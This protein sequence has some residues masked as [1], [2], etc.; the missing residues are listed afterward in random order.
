V[1]G[2]LGGLPRPEVPPGPQRDLVDALHALHHEAGWPSLRVLAREAGCSHTTV[3]AV[4][5]S[6]RLPTWGVLELVVEAMR[7]NVAEFHRLWLAASSAPVGGPPPAPRIAGRRAELAVVR[8]HLEDGAGLLLVTGEAGIGKTRLVDTAADSVPGTFVARGACLPLSAQVPLMPISEVLRAVHDVDQGQWL[9]EALAECAPYVVASLRRLLP[10]L[11]QA[12]D[13]PAVPDDDWWRQR[14]LAAVAAVLFALADL[15]PLAVVVED[16]HWADSATLDVLEYL[17]A[18]TTRVPLVATFRSEDPSVPDDRA[19]WLARAQR[20]RTVSTLE[21]SVLTREESAELVDLLGSSLA[22]DHLDRIHRRS[23]GLPLFT[24]QLASHPTGEEGLPRALADVLDRRLADI[25]ADE[26]WTVVRAL[27]VADRPLADTQ[28]RAVTGLA[29]A[30]LTAALRDLRARRLVAAA[31]E[32]H[33]VHLQHPLLAE[34][35]RRRLIPGEAG[36]EHRRLAAVLA[37][38]SDP[39]AAEV[40][41]HWRGA[42]EPHE[43]LR[44]RIRAAREAGAR[45]AAAQEAEQWRRALEVW[46]E[47]DAGADDVAPAGM[48]RVDACLAAMD[49]LMGIDWPAASAMA[50]EALR[51]LTDPDGADAAEVYRRTADVRGTLGDPE[52]GLELLDRALRIFGTEPSVGHVNALVSRD[53][54]LCGLDRYAEA[55]AAN[56]AAAAMSAALGD[57]P[58][59]RRSVLAMQAGHEFESGAVEEALERIQAAYRV[60]TD[61]P[62][63]RGD[64]HLA[65][66]H[67]HLLMTACRG[68][69]EEVVVAARPGL[70][71]A[72]AWGLDDFGTRVLLGNVAAVLRQAGR[73]DEAAELID[74]VTEGPPAPHQWPTYIERG[75]L[76]LLRGRGPEA[77]RLLDALA[78]TYVIDLANRV[79]C[80]QEAPTAD[81]W[82]G[83]PTVAYERLFGVLRDVVAVRDE[84]VD[85]AGLL[86]LA[87]R[88]AADV[89]EAS[90]GPAPRRRLLGELEGLLARAAGDPFSVPHVNGARR[91]LGASWAAEL[92][93]L[94]GAPSLERWA[95]AAAEWD[96]IGRPHDAAYCRW[97]GAQVA[98]A[99][100]QAAVAEKLLRRAGREARQHVPLLEAIATTAAAT[101]VGA[102]R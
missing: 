68:G 39:A 73:V 28:L 97:R 92:G 77:T 9:K 91:A 79:S 86:A 15:R 63:P 42:E 96:H 30:A 67:T 35:V 17:L 72:A 46:P 1:G 51:S 12:T 69:A 45:F 19:E 85:V 53:L 16:L 57:E 10:E 93:R 21:L 38:A 41:E 36:A 80:A 65:N 37:D 50:G 18:R 64:I 33:E 60:E 99:A 81:L 94:A 40:A 95:T 6:P 8:R 54:L 32:G 101:R 2:A 88:A 43:E 55:L 66:I 90:T 89:A 22:P 61:G 23:A 56:A 62:D 87:A 14:M 70:E 24:E 13:G 98:L 49:A 52:G 11:D 83:R 82:C 31:G 44:W 34:A 100:G 74:P 48:R 7:G 26:E 71:A 102:A 5:S 4:F 78:E 29:T 3:S 20:L 76:D 59:L 27:G 58:H 47:A 25:E 75:V 84:G